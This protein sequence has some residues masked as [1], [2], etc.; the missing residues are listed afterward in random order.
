VQAVS[1]FYVLTTRPLETKLNVTS[2]YRV[3]R[4]KLERKRH[5][6]VT[7]RLVA[8]AINNLVTS[9]QPYLHFFN[10]TGS[11]NEILFIKS[12]LRTQ[13]ALERGADPRSRPR[14]GELSDPTGRVCCLH[15]VAADSGDNTVDCWL[16]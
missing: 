15:V 3:L 4:P 14:R 8:C 7:S 10:Y 2:S 13:R 16:Y 12:M 6:V 1:L 5:V 9:T 11:R